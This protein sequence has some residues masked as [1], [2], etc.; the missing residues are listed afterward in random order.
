MTTPP[1]VG[2]LRLVVAAQ[3]FS[4][5]LR[6][7][8]ITRAGETALRPPIAGDRLARWRTTPPRSPSRCASASKTGPA[9]SPISRA[10]NADAGER[11]GGV[12]NSCLHDPRC[13]TCRRARTRQPRQR[14]GLIRVQTRCKRTRRSGPSQ[15]GMSGVGDRRNPR[16]Y[17]TSRHG[18]SLLVAAGGE[19]AVLGSPPG[20]AGLTAISA[21]GGRRRAP[22]S[23]GPTGNGGRFRSD[24]GTCRTLRVKTNRF[25]R[26][27]PKGRTLK[28][29][30]GVARHLPCAAHVHPGRRRSA[31]RRPEYR[32]ESRSQRPTLPVMQPSV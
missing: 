14:V 29:R 13:D 20:H 22:S 32:S 11:H 27:C 10:K 19:P 24:P 2:R 9:P 30:G 5:D 26:R 16:L 17:C 12:A 6:T 23:S 31:D 18:L 3:R 15:A 28:K 8:L 1:E 4:E 21:S 25:T 7:D